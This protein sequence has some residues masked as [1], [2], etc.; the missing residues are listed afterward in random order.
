MFIE[1]KYTKWYYNIVNNRQQFPAEFGE[2]HHII[3]KSIGGSNQKTNIVCLTAREHYICHR[4]LVKITA[5]I[6]CQKM[7]LA[8]DCF[9]KSIQDRSGFK[10]NSRI[11]A[12][13]RKQ[14]KKYLSS[15]RKGNAT[16]PAGT[17]R[18][19]EETKQKQSISA[20]GIAKRQPGYSHSSE[21]IQ[22]MKQN[23]KG[24]NL[25]TPSWNKGISQVC[26]HCKNQVSGTLNRWHGDNCKFK[27]AAEQ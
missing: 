12:E 13:S 27:N 26:P 1:S 22:L 6:N 25:G 23:R 8:L 11:V 20:K 9:T 24:K 14:S 18:H 19:S 17:Y 5:G 7:W 4:L 10:V 16:R 3:P 2:K 15:I 21:T